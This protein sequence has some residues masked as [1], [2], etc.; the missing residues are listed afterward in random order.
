MNEILKEKCDQEEFLTVKELADLLKVPVSWVYSRTRLTGPD[1]IPCLS[2]GK[3]KRFLK[4]NVLE[5]L[6]KQQGAA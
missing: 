1:T 2:C 5:W 6:E 4:N 3:Y